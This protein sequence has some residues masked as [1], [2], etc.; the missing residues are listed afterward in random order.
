MLLQTYKHSTSHD[1]Y[2]GYYKYILM[3]Q[4]ICKDA[5]SP[6]YVEIVVLRWVVRA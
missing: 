4:D 6:C 5:V 3:L 2:A 1:T